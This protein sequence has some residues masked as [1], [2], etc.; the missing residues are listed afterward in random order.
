MAQNHLFMLEFAVQELVITQANECAPPEY[1]LNAEFTFRSG[2]YVSIPEDDFGSV[3]DESLEDE[4]MCPPKRLSQNNNP[5]KSGQCCLFALENP[6]KEDELL[7]IHVYKKRTERCKFLIGATEL[8]VKEMFDNVMLKYNDANNNQ[9][10]NGGSKRN[11]T[12][13]NGSL[14]RLSAGQNEEEE[15][16]AAPEADI[17]SGTKSA[18]GTKTPPAPGTAPRPENSPSSEVSPR[19]TN[20]HIQ[21]HARSLA[22]QRNGD[23][24]KHVMP[25]KRDVP[26]SEVRKMGMPLY[27]LEGK[28]TGSMVVLIRL[29]CMGRTVCTSIPYPEQPQKMAAKRPVCEEDCRPGGAN[30]CADTCLARRAPCGAG[31]EEVVCGEGSSRSSSSSSSSN[32]TKSKY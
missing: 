26:V 9:I 6:V 4:L 31:I 22:E 2:V 27:N 5:N 20:G 14:K 29:S 28:G 23:N 10:S 7:M 8:K 3:K 19:P 15:E 13:S 25:P 12:K 17:V 24:H 18:T 16:E 11:S 30:V 32:S 1:P 21:D